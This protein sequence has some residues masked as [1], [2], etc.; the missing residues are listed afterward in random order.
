[1]KTIHHKDNIKITLALGAVLL[2]VFLVLRACGLIEDQPQN[3][4]QTAPRPAQTAEPA[5]PA[6]GSGQNG[7]GQS[8]KAF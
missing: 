2:L 5:R 4:E 6:A 7:H 1:M 3:Q 8:K